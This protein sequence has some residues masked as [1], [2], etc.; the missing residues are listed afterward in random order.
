MEVGHMYIVLK[1]VIYLLDN[2]HTQNVNDILVLVPVF[3][4]LNFES[5]VFQ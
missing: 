3:Q 4:I 5:H 1:F 2:K